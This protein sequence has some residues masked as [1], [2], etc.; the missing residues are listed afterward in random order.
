M[1]VA[2]VTEAAVAE[3]E[4]EEV[5]TAIAYATVI[6]FNASFA[7]AN[8]THAGGASSVIVWSA[9]IWA[10]LFGAMLLV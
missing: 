4:E 2:L 8:T 10:G 6:P 1:P 5:V 9:A 7:R 3:E